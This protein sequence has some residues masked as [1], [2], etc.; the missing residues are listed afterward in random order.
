MAGQHHK[1]WRAEEDQQLGELVEAGK[2]WVF[3]SVKLKRSIKEV[4]DPPPAFKASIA[5]GKAPRGPA[6]HCL[7]RRAG[8]GS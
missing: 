8:A 6:E 4:Q 7:S 5:V 3:I 2:S 1:L